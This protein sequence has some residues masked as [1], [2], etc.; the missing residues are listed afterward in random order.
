MLAR[1]DDSPTY[2]RLIFK[3]SFDFAD[4]DAEAADFVLIVEA[5]VEQKA[6]L[7]VN[8]YRIAP[9]G[10]ARARRPSGRMDWR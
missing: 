9:C 7:R 3:S 5:A 10:R 1:R 8:R 4:L 2:A 6:T